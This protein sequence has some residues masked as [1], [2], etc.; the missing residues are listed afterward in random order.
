MELAY[1]RPKE[2]VLESTMIFTKK[3][4]EALLL[5]FFWYNTGNMDTNNMKSE[6]EEVISW[7]KKEYSSIRTS[8]ATPAILD[9]VMVEAYGVMSPL[10]QVA[11]I[12]I[13][14]AK[15]LLVSPYD[16]GQIKQ[17]EKILNDSDLGLSVVGGD[18]GIR[19]SFPDL[20][21]ERRVMLGK[22]AKDKLED[23]R[24]SVRK[25]R[26]DVWGKI[27]ADEK[28][29]EISEDEKYSRK[30]KMEEVI[31]EYNVKLDE[32]YKLKEQEVKA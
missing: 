19:L 15:T 30:E 11:S 28:N 16:K 21:A 13:S 22:L 3:F 23:A 12:T 18:T 14:D 27:Q 1:Q 2:R 9:G 17:I 24:V 20:T 26:D 6:L 5:G 8:M 7:L 25:V 10:N 32:I 4:R 31:K 29:G